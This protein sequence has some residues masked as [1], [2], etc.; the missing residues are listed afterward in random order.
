MILEQFVE[1]KEQTQVMADPLDLLVT[2]II[3]KEHAPTEIYEI[4]TGSGAWVITQFKTGITAPEYVLIDDFSWA[5]KGWSGHRFWPQDE[6]DLRNY[7]DEQTN[8][9]LSFKIVNSDIYDYIDIMKSNINTVRID[10]DP[11]HNGFEKI[12]DKLDDTGLLLV[13]DVV[14]NMGLNRIVNLIDF[15]RQGKI[16]P[17][18]IGLKESAWVKNKDYRDQL[19]VSACNTIKENYDIGLTEYDEPYLNIDTWKYFTT[20]YHNFSEKFQNLKQS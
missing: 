17:L 3:L 7:V 10:M 8:H 20:R 13:D 1:I 18:W 4:G 16:Y 14:F 2:N 11:D 9:K 6:L 15:K 19:Y 12:I 5:A